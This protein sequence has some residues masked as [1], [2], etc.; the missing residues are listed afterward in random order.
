MTNAHV[1]YSINKY[2]GTMVKS[3]CTGICML[4][5]GECTG[6]GRTIEEITSWRSMSPEEQN[7][8]VEAIESGA[9]KYPTDE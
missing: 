4:D 5:N 2:S 8:V 9:R 1:F 7:A 6:C 3:P